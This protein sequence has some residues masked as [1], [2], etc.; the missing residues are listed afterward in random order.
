MYS[1]PKR[2]QL[3][4]AATVIIRLGIRSGK[5]QQWKRGYSKSKRE[6]SGDG[7]SRASASA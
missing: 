6:D 3:G 1:R 4:V 7:Q 5:G 2:L